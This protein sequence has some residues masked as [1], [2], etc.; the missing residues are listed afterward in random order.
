MEGLVP[1]AQS[2]LCP[3]IGKTVPEGPDPEVPNP[4]LLVTAVTQGR[5]WWGLKEVV[6]G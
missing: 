4:A 3:F 2:S 1:S 5:S 6:L